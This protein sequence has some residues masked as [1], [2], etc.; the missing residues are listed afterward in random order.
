MPPRSKRASGV[1]PA[2]N[3]YGSTFRLWDPTISGWR[4]FWNDPARNQY[5]QQVGR[6]S[7]SD[8]VQLGVRPDGTATR[9]M[10]VEIGPDSFHWLGSALER[11]GKSWRLE[12]EF[13][14]TRTA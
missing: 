1:D 9:W 6:R 7:G 14:A 10:F 3:M 12:G 11:D 2:D 4:I 5:D 13:L 8:I